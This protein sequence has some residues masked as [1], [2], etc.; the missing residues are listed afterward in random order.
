MRRVLLLVA[1]AAFCVTGA[2]AQRRASVPYAGRWD[3]TLDTPE[4]NYP[5]WIEV[6]E[7]DGTVQ[8]LVVGREGSLHG[9][10]H[11]RLDPRASTSP[12][13]NETAVVM[14]DKTV[15]SELSFTTLENFGGKAGQTQWQI[16]SDGGKLTGVQK[17][18]DG[19]GAA[20]HGE[21]AP[22]L[23]RKAPA[24][25]TTPEPLF[26]GTDLTGWQP[27]GSA[28]DSHES[29]PGPI[30]LQGDHTGGM[31]FRNITVSLPAK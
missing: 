11:V 5:S 24:A 22:A 29:Q 25:W 26:N 16:D 17:R 18:P 19:I 20:I 7:K 4:G 27:L 15:A 8:V 30:Y 21:R 12:A 23:K 2:S 1:A 6:S 9:S 28:L 14:G 3:L 31:K 10:D 13:L